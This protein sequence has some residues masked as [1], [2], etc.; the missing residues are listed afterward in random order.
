MLELDRWCCDA[1]VPFSFASRRFKGTSESK[2]N[3]HLFL[4]FAEALAAKNRDTRQ[5]LIP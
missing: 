2:L 5:L 1:D 4:T 3:V